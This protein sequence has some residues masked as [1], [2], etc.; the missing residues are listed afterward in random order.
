MNSFL[1]Y[2]IYL[3][4]LLFCLLTGVSY[5]PQVNAKNTIIEFPFITGGQLKVS[6]GISTIQGTGSI[7]LGRVKLSVPDSDLD[8]SCYSC[9]FGLEGW[10]YNGENWVVGFPPQM[11]AMGQSGQTVREF[12]NR[13]NKRVPLSYSVSTYLINTALP[14]KNYRFC[15]ALTMNNGGD[16]GKNSAPLMNVIKNWK[17]FDRTTGT[18]NCYI[19]PPNDVFCSFK[20]SNISFEFGSMNKSEVAGASM[21]KDFIVT[22]NGSVDFKVR[23]ATWS[24]SIVLS[25]GMSAALKLNS[26]GFDDIIK[27]VSGDNAFSLTTTLEGTPDSLGA[28]SGNTVMVLDYI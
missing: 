9:Y 13:I 14:N 23:T 28:F 1:R 12:I 19:P 15:L 11:Y 22:C 4:T 18:G 10:V 20:N 24:E 6:G 21:K 17:E 16:R 25:N 26:G 27:G 5:S 8:A 7:S 3:P 2:V